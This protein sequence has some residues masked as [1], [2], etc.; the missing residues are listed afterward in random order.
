MVRNLSVGKR[1]FLGF[2]VVTLIVLLLGVLALV[3]MGRVHGALSE[4]KDVWL[5]GT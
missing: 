5:L 4:V 2:A 3:Q 1:N